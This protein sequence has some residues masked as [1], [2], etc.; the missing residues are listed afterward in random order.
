[1]REFGGQRSGA[2][3]QPRDGRSITTNKFRLS[4]ACSGVARVAFAASSIPAAAQTPVDD[5]FV[6]GGAGWVATGFM[7][8]KGDT[9]YIS[10]DGQVITWLPP[11]GGRSAGLMASPAPALA[12]ADTS[13]WW[14]ARRGARWWE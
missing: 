2:R 14:R 7:A 4:L 8:D 11:R 12:A 1:M 6:A 5:V 10:A 9:L 13:S 3:V